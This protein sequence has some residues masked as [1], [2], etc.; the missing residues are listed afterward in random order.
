MARIYASVLGDWQTAPELQ[1]DVPFQLDDADP[2][3]RTDV[4]AIGRRSRDLDDRQCDRVLNAR[5]VLDVELEFERP[6]DHEAAARVARFI[7]LALAAGGHAAY[8]ETS[9]RVLG[10]RALDRVEVDDRRTLLHLCVQVL[11]DEVAVTTEGMQCFDLPDVVARHDGARAAPRDDDAPEPLPGEYDDADAAQ[12]ACFGFAARMV[13]DRWRPTSG[14]VFR[15][16]ESAPWYT[17]KLEAAGPEAA[18]D[19]FVNPRGRWVL[20]RR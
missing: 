6:G 12:A 11:M 15:A 18:D 3:L 20:Q 9:A 19:P 10:P 17:A 16:S 14:S 1:T 8:L 7:A 5:S 13:C 4:A 2:E